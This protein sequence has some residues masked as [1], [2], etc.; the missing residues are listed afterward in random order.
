[1]PPP[2]PRDPL[3]FDLDHNGKIDT[4]PKTHGVNFDLD[5]SGFAERTS[6]IGSS[7]A[8]LVLDRNGNGAIDGGAELFGTETTLANGSLARNGFEALAEFDRN[9]DGVIDASDEIFGDLRLWQDA[10]SDGVANAGE[11]KTLAELNVSSIDVSYN[12]QPFTDANNV[13]HREIGAFRYGDGSTGLTNTLWFDSDRRLTVPVG[14]LNGNGI[15]VPPEIARLPDAVGFGNVHTLHRAMVLDTSGALKAAVEAFVAATDPAQRHL[16][17]KQILELWTHQEN[18]NP[19]S[20][21]G[22][23]DARTIGVMESFLGQPAL[24]VNP[25]GTYA[26]SLQRAYDQLA[27]SVYTQ[28]MSDSHAASLLRKVSFSEVN[29]VWSADFAAVSAVFAQQFTSGQAGVGA[30]LS[31]FMEVVR[32]INPYD[33]TM[34]RHF[35]DQLE[36]QAIGLAPDVKTAMMTVVWAGNDTILGTA[37]RDSINGYTGNDTI[38]G[39]A[40][41]DWL[42]GGAGH[43]VI[44]GGD[45]MDLLSGDDGNDLLSGNAGADVLIGGTGDDTLTG[46]EGVDHAYGGDG[47]D[48]LYGD[49]AYGGAGGNDVLDGGAGNDYLVGGFGSDTYLFGRGDGQD[50]INNDSDGWNGYADPTPGKQD[51]LQFKPDVLASD[52][53]LSRNGDNLVLRINGTT[54]QVTISNYFNNDGVS[55]RGWA[56]EQIRFNDGT[57]W[58]VTTV[59]A[60]LLVSATDANDTITGYA[61]DDLIAGQGGNDALYGRDGNDTLDGGDGGDSLNGENGN[62][63]LIGGAGADA[64]T[65][66]VGADTLLGGDGN[67][68][69]YGDGQYGGNGGNDV[70]DGG[71][72][73]DYLVGGFGSDTYRF[74]RGD[75]QDSINNDSDGWNGSADP[76]VGKADVLQFKAGV[77][78]SDVSLTRSGDNLIVS[79][80]GTADQVTISNYFNGDGVSARTW[81]VEQ[82]RFDDGTTWSVADVKA[83]L[84]VS[85]TSANDTITAYATDDVVAGLAG[86]DALYGR[87]GNDTLDGGDG[88]DSLNGENGNDSLIGGVGAD[89]LTGGVGADTLLGGVGNDNLYGDGQYGGN[90]G[91]DVLDGGAG[92]DY[93][94]G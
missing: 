1:M 38:D 88:G 13:Q 4:I 41:D 92:N 90:G 10:N 72:G 32:G 29:G 37:S 8:M 5:N 62:D 33:A 25:S 47:N 66:G 28:L 50:T 46:G 36:A 16:L 12:T 91:N 89:A 34:Y 83:R 42:W 17:V 57:S 11:L 86:D 2:P 52:V 56:V 82:I 80:N 30:K 22:V 23:V 27:A 75:G 51:V 77:L 63:S 94:V 26:Q 7:D 45:G 35:I 74:G 21:G 44:N 48:Y 79:I 19:A 53:S 67:D 40:G 43:D 49:G 9:T 60:R 87:D 78:S 69:L 20:R 73:N 6:W 54:D 65:G 3:A 58:D 39:K 85:A 64:L 70:L 24:Q 68:N 18:V 14:Q 59:K 71:A 15:V 61:T 84:L 31:D 76:T 93:L 55:T 81:A